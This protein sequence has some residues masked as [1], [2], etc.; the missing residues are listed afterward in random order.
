MEKRYPMQD[1]LPPKN[2][3]MFPHTPGI[4]LMASGT[5]LTHKPVSEAV[6][7]WVVPSKIVELNIT[8]YIMAPGSKQ[9]LK[10]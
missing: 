4:A 1:R 10:L 9:D 5:E 6:S 3:S 8:T 7:E 2:V